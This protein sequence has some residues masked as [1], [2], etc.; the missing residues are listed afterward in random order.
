MH[1]PVIFPYGSNEAVSWG[2]SVL[3]HP[4]LL[5]IG[6]SIPVCLWTDYMSGMH[7]TLWHYCIAVYILKEHSTTVAPAAAGSG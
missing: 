5:S 1:A 4:K 6:L 2:R 3:N 7:V